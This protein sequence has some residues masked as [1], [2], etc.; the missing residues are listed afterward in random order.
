MR[1][2]TAPN[3]PAALGPYSHAVEHG[4]VVYVSGQIGLDPA[5]GK[6]AGESFEAQA[7]QVLANLATVLHAAGCSVHTLLQVDIFLT[8]MANFPV[9]NSL[10][11]AFLN[12]HKPARATVEVAALPAGALVE[13]KA[14]AYVG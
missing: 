3:A 8:D 14:V 2:I 13:I 4:G 7:K 6:L 11:E 9:L 10:Y 12:G 5:T 1:V